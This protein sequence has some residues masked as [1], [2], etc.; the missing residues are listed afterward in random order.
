ME[1]LETEDSGEPCTVEVYCRGLRTV[2]SLE[3]EDSG[4]PCTVEV[5]CRGVL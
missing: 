1:S 2:E 5:Y 4:E 3:T